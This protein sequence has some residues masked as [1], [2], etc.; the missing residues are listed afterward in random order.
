MKSDIEFFHGEDVGAVC[1]IGPVGTVG[2]VGMGDNI[3]FAY[4][5]NPRALRGIDSGT[6]YVFLTGRKPGQNLEKWQV[7]L[8][9]ALQSNLV[10][11]NEFF[12]GRKPETIIEILRQLR[13][14]GKFF[15]VIT[16]DYYMTKALA[17][18]QDIFYMKGDPF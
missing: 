9:H 3:D 14:K 6:L 18:P 7:M 12:P 13:D 15:L 10:V 5:P 1:T 8:E 2:I 4:L 17:D 16:A 11:M